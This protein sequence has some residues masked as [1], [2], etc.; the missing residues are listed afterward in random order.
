MFETSHLRGSFRD[1]WSGGSNGVCAA[2]LPSALV[3]Q[4]FGA[5]LRYRRRGSEAPQLALK[6][7][8]TFLSSSVISNAFFNA[9]LIQSGGA[10]AL[11]SPGACLSR[12]FSRR[13][14]SVFS[15]STGE[16]KR[17]LRPLA[18]TVWSLRR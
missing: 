13:G 8:R 16:A 17:I 9:W 11:N 7:A 6:P 4:A 3:F 18:Q 1:W 10:G 15:L 14:G 2:V 12:N 5:S